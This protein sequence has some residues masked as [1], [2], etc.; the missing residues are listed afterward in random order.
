MSNIKNLIKY[1]D[2]YVACADASKTNKIIE[3]SQ[4]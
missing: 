3:L 1:N 4:F 2:Q